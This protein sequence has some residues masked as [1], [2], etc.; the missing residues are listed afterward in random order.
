MKQKIAR[1][2]SKLR[3]L[4]GHL[5]DLSRLAQ[6]VTVDEHDEETLTQQVVDADIILTCY[7]PITAQ[8]IGSTKRL[9]GIVTYG[10]GVDSIDVAA[11]TEKGIPSRE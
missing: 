4:E 3:I 7:E 2:D 1:T 8:V 10:V 5:G 11:A 6:I 9:K